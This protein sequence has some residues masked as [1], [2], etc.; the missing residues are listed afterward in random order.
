MTTTCHTLN[1]QNCINSPIFADPTLSGC[2]LL[3]NP[4][5]TLLQWKRFGLNG[6]TCSENPHKS[7][8]NK[9]WIDCIT[10]DGGHVDDSNR[11]KKQKKL[12]WKKQFFFFVIIQHRELWTN[13]LFKAITLKKYLEIVRFGIV[14]TKSTLYPTIQCKMVIL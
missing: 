1:R 13:G 14:R 9:P 5:R 4:K 2:Y 10:F 11:I 6:E 12:I 8:Y 3:G 7:F